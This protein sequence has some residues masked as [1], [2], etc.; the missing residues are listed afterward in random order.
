MVLNGAVVR[1]DDVRLL[2]VYAVVRTRD[3]QDGQIG[4]PNR[5]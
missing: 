3:S 5:S 1:Q 4:L 2:G